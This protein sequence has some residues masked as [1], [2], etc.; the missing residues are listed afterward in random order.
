MTVCLVGCAEEGQPQAKETVSSIRNDE[1]V[2]AVKKGRILIERAGEEQA[3]LMNLSEISF[4]DEIRKFNSFTVHMN[5]TD[6]YSVR[7]RICELEALAQEKGG[8]ILIQQEAEKAES[9][10]IRVRFPKKKATKFA[11][12]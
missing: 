6:F 8:E 11:I 7:T 3:Q 2:E 12:P 5:R 1:S 4:T 9:P 10:Y